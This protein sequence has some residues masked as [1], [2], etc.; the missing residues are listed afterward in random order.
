M[1]PKVIKI[2][3]KRVNGKDVV[4]PD[5]GD[6]TNN[7][8]QVDKSK[9][10]SV[11]FDASAADKTNKEEDRPTID[12][13]GSN[14]SP[15]GNQTVRYGVPLSIAVD[16]GVFTYTCKMKIGGTLFETESGGEMEII[17]G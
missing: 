1:P 2:V 15:F 6:P 11:I 10:D 4:G 7:R 3:K 17:G 12:F 5:N 13:V 8:T 14:G 16:K 9:T